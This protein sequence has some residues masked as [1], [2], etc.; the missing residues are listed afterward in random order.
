MCFVGAS[1]VAVAAAMLV[2][3]LLCCITR[4]D[5][6]CVWVYVVVKHCTQVVFE[7]KRSV[8]FLR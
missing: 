1:A 8:G 6:G 2:A 5:G 3:I 4:L 7:L